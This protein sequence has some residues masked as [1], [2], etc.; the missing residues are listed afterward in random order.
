MVI[1]VFL[2]FF[3]DGSGMSFA[4]TKLVADTS[5]FYTYGG[6]NFDEARDIKETPDKGYI[7]AGTTSSFGQGATSVYM[8]K[9]DSSGNHTWS[10]VQGGA[11]NDHAY[12][13]EL[14]YDGG[15]FVAGYS[16]SFYSGN[17]FD[18]SAYFFKTDANGNLL[19][20]KFIDN[21]SNSF[22][23]GAC[24]VPAD[25]GFILCGQT[26]ATSFGTADAYLIRV[27]K[28]GN[29]I[30]TNHYGDSLDEVF[31]SVCLINNKIYAVG[32]NGSHAGADSTADGWLMKLDAAGN[33][34]QDTFITYG[35]KQ[36]ETL[37]GITPYNSN[38]F[39]V[40]GANTHIDSNATTPL[41][42]KYDTSLVINQDITANNGLGNHSPGWFVEF[43]KVINISY[44]NICAVGSADGGVGGIDMFYMG[45][46]SGGWFFNNFLHH[47]G[48]INN[49]YGYNGIYSSRGR[50][51][52]VGSAYDFGN[53]PNYCSNPN[54]GL[55]DVF[56]VRFNSDSINNGA[57]SSTPQTNCFADTL[58]FSQASIKNYTTNS[59]VKLFPNPNNGLFNLSINQF[60]NE[61][62]N[63]IEIYN[64][65]GECVHR[66]IATSPNCQIDVSNLSN[67]TY[68][69]KIQ[70]EN[71]Q[72]L[73]VLKFI[74][75]R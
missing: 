65:I 18:Y 10:G 43:N 14:T 63:R 45:F 15:F 57:I 1:V 29:T 58:Y 31:N 21:G 24:S 40:C 13:V 25:S 66:Q 59:N 11:E 39:T 34:L 74:I 61:K 50:V 41:L 42:A 47:S 56:L 32:S 49:D 53:S 4:Q 38:L 68:I 30:W 28:N 48:G 62:T 72:T 37:N 46:S 35:A 5:F 2:P 60:G 64:M 52:F 8:I 20:Q 16:N 19:W 9:M 71:E 26:Y 44:G 36:Q 23:Y 22:I 69:I 3:W 75:S 27:D 67:G 70:D 7:L 55:E 6:S 17:S 12:A 33:K 54:M 51:L 73:S